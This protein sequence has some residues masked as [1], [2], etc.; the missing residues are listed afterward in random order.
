MISAIVALQQLFGGGFMQPLKYGNCQ[1][2]LGH[3]LI[4]Y[5]RPL[6]A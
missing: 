3:L 6:E 1:K 5:A 4:I 2:T